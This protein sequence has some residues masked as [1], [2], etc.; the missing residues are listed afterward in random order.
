M[1]TEH[2]DA[3]GARR[4]DFINIAAVSFA[5]VGA[6]AATIPLIASMSASADVLAV[7]NIEVDISG[8]AVG[9]ALVAMYQ[10]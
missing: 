1:A 7:A 4:R 5:G 6:A 2:I 9:E 10:N 3:A 8:I